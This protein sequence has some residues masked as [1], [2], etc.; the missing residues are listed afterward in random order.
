MGQ[1]F[2]GRHYVSAYFPIKLED[3]KFHY[4]GQERHCAIY[5]QFVLDF[6]SS[7]TISSRS[8]YPFYIV[9]YYI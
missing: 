5:G 4:V 1:D 6:L 8:S 3:H 7:H 2:L 9:T